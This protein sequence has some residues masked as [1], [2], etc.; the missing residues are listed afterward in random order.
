[1]FLYQQV[2][3]MWDNTRKNKFLDRTLYTKFI[4]RE[5]SVSTKEC[6][7]SIYNKYIGEKHPVMLETHY[8]RNT[9]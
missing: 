8:V 3:P 4:G 6:M 9:I 1:M 7:S 5:M 2:G